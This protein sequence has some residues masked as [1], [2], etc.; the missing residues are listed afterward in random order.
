MNILFLL[1]VSF[2]YVGALPYSPP[3]T[4]IIWDLWSRNA[5]TSVSCIDLR[6][7]L[8]LN[9]GH[10]S[11][12]FPP[13]AAFEHFALF[14]LMAKFLLHLRDV[15]ILYN[16]SCTCFS[17]SSVG[18]LPLDPPPPLFLVATSFYQAYLL[19]CNVSFSFRLSTT[20]SSA[21]ILPFLLPGFEFHA[22]FLGY[23]VFLFQEDFVDVHRFNKHLIWL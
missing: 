15:D 16:S 21:S 18:T 11:S 17:A 9:R 3:L 13:S 7:P 20:W 2:L 8:F 6:G 5:G 10:C 22:E 14:Q 12:Y 1:F 19:W 23:H 4:S